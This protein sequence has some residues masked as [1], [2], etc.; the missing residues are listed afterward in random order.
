[1]SILDT[2][3]SKAGAKPPTAPDIEKQLEP[4]REAVLKL[5]A[6]IGHAAIDAVGDDPA[7]LERY[8][9]TKADL[10]AA[11]DRLDLLNR[12]HASAI[13]RDKAELAGRQAA[14]RKTQIESR[15]RDA[16]ALRKLAEDFAAAEA[17]SNRLY[18]AMLDHAAKLVIPV[19]GITTPDDAISPGRMRQLV[20]AERFRLSAP[21]SG[22][23][24]GRDTLR[25]L[26]GAGSPDVMA[27]DNPEIVPAFAD[28][29]RAEI[30]AFIGY[31]KEQAD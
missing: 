26:P 13:E 22:G 19:A 8:R 4:A 1:M 7:A 14:I 20:I 23:S 16:T 2:S 15:K 6:D 12:A 29:V 21:F 5:E 10:A 25:L 30:S 24:I 27:D 31:L 11:H 18:Q 28:A 9:K 3:K 17:E